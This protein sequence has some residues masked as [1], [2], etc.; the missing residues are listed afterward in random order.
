MK[1][2][3][4]ILIVLLSASGV[5]ADDYYWVGGAG[6]WSDL[7]HWASSSGGPGNKSIV[8]GLNDDVY[9]DGNSGLLNNT[10]VTMPTT[11]HA[12]VRNISWAGVTTNAIFRNIAVTYQLNV[13]GNMELSGAMRYDIRNILFAGT[14][15]ATLKMNGAGKY[16]VANAVNAVNVNKPGGSLTLLDGAPEALNVNIVLTTG[17]VNLSGNTHALNLFNG[18]SSTSTRSADISNA[19]LIIGNSRDYRGANGTL[20]ATGS[21]IKAA[22]F[23][24]DRYTFP[25]VEITGT[26]D[27]MIITTSTFGELT[28]S[29][30][31]TPTGSVRIGGGN[32]VDRLEFMGGGRIATG[33]S[34]INQLILAPGKGYIFHGTNTINTRMQLNTPDCEGL[35]QLTG[36]DANAKLAFATGAVVDLRNVYVK[37]LTATGA[38]T[39][40]TV[41]GA[42]GGSNVGWNFL[43]RPSGTTL[44]WVG[45]AGD[46]NDKS[47]W[48]SASGGTGGACVPLP[49]MMWCSTP[50]VDLPQAI[51]RYR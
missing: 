7:S 5:H 43:P 23:Q 11:G 1:R 30:P 37:T 17:H 32:T 20:N 22:V 33:G 2:L 41:V 16:V 35:G 12:Y 36:A 19:T 44:Y 24:S 8:P 39:P 14:G 4:L 28:F 13:Y 34:V 3:I 49:G 27:L 42:D 51:T 15:N 31:A 10:I 45:G 29:N 50:T 6:S 48:S 26:S 9:F 47:H 18:S 25:K 21:S 46:W 38:V 40:I